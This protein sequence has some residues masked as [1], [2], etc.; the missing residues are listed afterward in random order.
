MTIDIS[1]L[2]QDPNYTPG[3]K[4]VG[5]MDRNGKNLEGVIT[6]GNVEVGKYRDTEMVWESYDGS[7]PN[8][9]DHYQPNY[10]NHP[11]DPHFPNNNIHFHNDPYAP[12]FPNDIHFHDHPYEHGHYVERVKDQGFTIREQ[13]FSDGTYNFVSGVLV[14]TKAEGKD[15]IKAAVDRDNNG[16]V[17]EKD[18]Q[19][20]VKLDASSWKPEDTKNEGNTKKVLGGILAVGGMILA[21]PVGLGIGAALGGMVLGGGLIYSGEKD[22][23]KKFDQIGASPAKIIFEQ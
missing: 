5:A 22:S 13:K 6:K 4:V 1:K 3:Y 2:P 17:S 7:F 10:P 18:T 23:Q 14:D 16:A 9:N 19:I 20:A 11:Y 12:Q 15:V 8:H 21:G